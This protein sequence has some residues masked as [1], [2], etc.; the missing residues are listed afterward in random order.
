MRWRG[1]DVISMDAGKREALINIAHIGRNV[2]AKVRL[3]WG[4][5]RQV[6]DGG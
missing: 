2:F 6:G 4:T 5:L 1:G 3:E